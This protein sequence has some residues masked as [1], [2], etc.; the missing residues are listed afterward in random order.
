M[1]REIITTELAPWPDAPLPQAVRVG[2][3]V[4]VSGLTPF[5]REI[6]RAKGRLGWLK[7]PGDRGT[8]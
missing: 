7:S 3:P 2:Q 8:R 1:A 6:G 4:F 5:T